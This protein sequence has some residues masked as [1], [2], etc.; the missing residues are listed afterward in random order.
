MNR[1]AKILITASIVGVLLTLATYFYQTSSV[2]FA[3]GHPAAVYFYYGFPLSFY[4]VTSLDASFVSY[5]QVDVLNG[6]AD[7]LL[8]FALSGVALAVAFVLYRPQLN[9]AQ[10]NSISR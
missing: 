9:K 7:F 10:E 5:H 6:V 1:T 2:G 3:S 8:Y 4:N